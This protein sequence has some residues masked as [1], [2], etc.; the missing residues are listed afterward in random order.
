MMRIAHGNKTLGD[1]GEMLGVSA[2]FVS[3]IETGKKSVPP[4]F[5][6]QLQAKLSLDADEV[7][8]LEVAA[9]KQAK[10]IS[11]GLHERTDRARELAVAFARRFENMSDADVEKMFNQ[12]DDL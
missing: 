4:S 1:L 2:A 6:N 5:I 3:A 9:A 11:M 12:L 10:E 7:R 8:R